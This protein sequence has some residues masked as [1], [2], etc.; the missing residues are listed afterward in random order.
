MFILP[1]AMAGAL[2]VLAVMLLASAKTNARAL[3]AQK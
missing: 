1:F 3:A 2:A